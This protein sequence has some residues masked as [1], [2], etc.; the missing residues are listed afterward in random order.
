MQI[1]IG[2][3]EKYANNQ[4][5]DDGSNILKSE[6]RLSEGLQFIISVLG[7]RQDRDL[8]NLGHLSVM[9]NGHGLCHGQG[10]SHTLCLDRTRQDIVDHGHIHDQRALH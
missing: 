8:A 4:K 6:S 5:Y 9:F 3:G 7:T 2:L 10:H 1:Y